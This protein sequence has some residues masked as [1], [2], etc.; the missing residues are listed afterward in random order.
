[1]AD[2][3]NKGMTGREL[4]SWRKKWGLSQA[5][6][7]QKLGVIRETVARWEVGIRS[8]PPFLPLALKWLETE[9]E[10]DNGDA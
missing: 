6:L 4:K 3:Y 7:A 2:K 8:I 9:L 10:E 1:V 5:A